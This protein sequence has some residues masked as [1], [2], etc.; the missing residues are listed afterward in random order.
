MKKLAII[1]TIVAATAMIF[2]SCGKYEEGPSFTV[3]SKKAR[4]TGVWDFTEMTVDGT[5]ID[6]QGMTMKTTILKDGTGTAAMTWAS[7]TIENDLE[8]E[9][10]DTKETLRMRTKDAD[11]TEWSEW[12]ESTISKLTNSELWMQDTEEDGGVDVVTVTKMTKE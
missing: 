5:V 2:S 4:V 7:I 1:L 8:W 6:M 12:T 9:F 11:D 3:L 10:N